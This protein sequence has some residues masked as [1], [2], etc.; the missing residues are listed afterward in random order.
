MQDAFLAYA[1]KEKLFTTED[2]LLLAISGGVD[3]MVMAHLL[4]SLGYKTG[5]AHCNFG[6]RGAASDGDEDMVRS[7]ADRYQVPFFSIRFETAKFAQK[8]KQSIQVA[9]RTLRY[10]WLKEVRLEQKFQYIATAHHLNDALET[11]FYNFA[12][13]CGI[14]GLLGIPAKNGAIV[15]PMLFAEKKQILE[16]AEEHRIEYRE[17][18][19]NAQ[20]KYARNKIRHKAIPVFQAIN[21]QFEQT[22]AENLQRL[23]EAARLIDWVVEKFKQTTFEVQEDKIYIKTDSLEDFGEAQSTVLYECLSVYGFNNGH[24]QGLK[25]ALTG[26]P[27]KIFTSA[28]HRLLVDRQRLILEKLPAPQVSSYQLQQ[29]DEELMVDKG[30]FILKKEIGVPSSLP[31][32]PFCIIM[33]ADRLC[34]PL[35]IRHW[36][37]GDSFR[38]L[39]MKG[40]HQKLQDFFSNHKITLFEKQRIWIVENGDNQICW[41][42]GYRL[43][44]NFKV[45]PAT[46]AHLI[47]KYQSIGGNL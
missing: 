6:L 12:K 4:Y 30:R 41:V 8:E 32:D 35:T 15:R 46:K 42:V 39:G 5:L 19:S 17:D 27:G 16:Y 14:K 37:E 7:V 44:D 18:A 2:K 13:G 47:L 20:T 31:T 24:I 10:K 23:K 38:P 43:D 26:Q 45:T 9:A 3:S 33:D 40:K 1:T 36:Q 34:F 11:F 25:I 29:E 21:P 28:T 22:G